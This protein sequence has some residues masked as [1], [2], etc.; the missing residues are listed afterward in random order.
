MKKPFVALA[1]L[2]AVSAAYAGNFETGKAGSGVGFGEYSGAGAQP[3][4]ILSDI[5]AAADAVPAPLN[6]AGASSTA[7]GPLVTVWGTLEIKNKNAPDILA[8]AKSI[9]LV[10]NINKSMTDG[11]KLATYVVKI[12]QSALRKFQ[13]EGFTVLE[14]ITVRMNWN[15]ISDVNGWGTGVTGECHRTWKQERTFSGER[16]NKGFQLVRDFTHDPIDMLNAKGMDYIFTKTPV[17][18]NERGFVVEDGIAV[19][20]GDKGTTD[21]QLLYQSGGSSGYYAVQ[22]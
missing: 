7:T 12:P 1:A 5:Q 9:V 20:T 16:L 6:M 3:Q 17:S 2:L 11:H 21:G 19:R 10:Y 22:P 4:P 8:E 18:T 13:A 15:R 14:Q